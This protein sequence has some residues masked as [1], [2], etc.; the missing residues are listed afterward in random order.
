MTGW[1]AG[2]L[3][4]FD[5]ETPAPAG[6]PQ[7]EGGTPAGAGLPLVIHVLGTPAPQ[8]SKRAFRHRTT[9]RVVTV[10]SAHERVQTWR[11]AVKAAAWA[12]LPS[13]GRYPF[14]SDPLTVE[15]TFTLARPKSHYRTGR[16]AHL[17]R[18][19]A[20][21]YPV[22]KPDLDKLTRSTFDAL[23]DA[24]VIGDDAMVAEV[25]AR[26]RYPRTHPDAGPLPGA[27][28]RVSSLLHTGG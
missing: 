13:T 8:G 25:V 15:I 18:D 16:N 10:E 20:P 1:A 7:G 2:P 21:E 4:G 5:L 3:I 23:V 22:T 27:V 17:L 6:N 14:G 9:G 24:G 26:K 11:E 12:A 19:N 28:I